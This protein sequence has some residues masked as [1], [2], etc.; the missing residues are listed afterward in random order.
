MRRSFTASLFWYE[1][2][3][4]DLQV[5]KNELEKCY[6]PKGSTEISRRIQLRAPPL[7]RQEKHYLAGGAGG[8]GSLRM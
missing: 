7:E 4:I 1:L 5:A 2:A 6:L 3:A 8:S